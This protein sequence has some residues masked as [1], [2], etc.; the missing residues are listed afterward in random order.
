MAERWAVACTENDSKLWG[1][2][3][4]FLRGLLCCLHWAAVTVSIE[5]GNVEHLSRIFEIRMK[6][7]VPRNAHDPKQHIQFSIEIL[8]SICIAC[9]QTH[10]TKFQWHFYQPAC[11]YNVSPANYRFHLIGARNL[12]LFHTLNWFPPSKHAKYSTPKAWICTNSMMEVNYFS[13]P[14]HSAWSTIKKKWK[15]ITIHIRNYTNEWLT[16]C[17]GCNLRNSNFRIRIRELCS[18]SSFGA[19]HRPARS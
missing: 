4:R 8:H 19:H 2:P 1:H 14:T 11:N 6:C 5:G 9:A 13:R 10:R 3:N 16:V 15:Q 18:H 7:V 17:P 12:L